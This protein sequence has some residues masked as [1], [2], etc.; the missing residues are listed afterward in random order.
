MS[1]AVELFES[2]RFP[3]EIGEG[4]NELQP[5]RIAKGLGR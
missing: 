2:G 5:L 3:Y 1:T 4:A